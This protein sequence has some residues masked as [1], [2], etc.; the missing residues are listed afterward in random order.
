MA[1]F[2]FF[3]FSLSLNSICKWRGNLESE[4][5]H[6][7]DPQFLYDAKE[8]KKQK[9]EPAGAFCRAEQTKTRPLEDRRRLVQNGAL[10]ILFRQQR[11]GTVTRKRFRSAVPVRWCTRAPPQSCAGLPTAR[12]DPNRWAVPSPSRK[13]RPDYQWG[14][15]ADRPCQRPIERQRRRQASPRCIAP[16]GPPAR[17]SA[18]D[19][20]PTTW[21]LHWWPRRRQSSRQAP[22]TPASPLMLSWWPMSFPCRSRIESSL[23]ASPTTT[24]TRPMNPSRFP[25]P[26]YLFLKQGGG[27]KT[28]KKI[29]PLANG[30][31]HTH[32]LAVALLLKMLLLLK[33][34]RNSISCRV[35]VL[36]DA[37]GNHN[38]TCLIISL[39]F[40]L[41]FFLISWQQQKWNGGI[42]SGP[43]M[44]LCH[45][46]T[47]SRVS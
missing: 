43:W 4:L 34:D 6:L 38:T 30:Y 8:N 28:R 36:R 7:I 23:G 32:T 11:M 29:S 22:M 14:P 10:T 3:S 41:S 19:G 31:P 42:P 18:D 25:V 9:I 46:K 40:F 15:S 27:R 44:K 21:R 24:T 37:P 33:Q 17:S 39:V 5:D 35:D 12:R 20:Q 26:F 47:F 2:S 45:T 13:T 16:L 1:S